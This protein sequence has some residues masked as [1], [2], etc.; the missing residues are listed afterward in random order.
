M[1]SLKWT[2]YPPQSADP[3]GVGRQLV[4]SG[5]SGA[6]EEASSRTNS[7]RIHVVMASQTPNPQ[8]P[9]FAT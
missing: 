9:I 3:L 8:L 1:D 4:C 2:F 5:E 6:E 7:M